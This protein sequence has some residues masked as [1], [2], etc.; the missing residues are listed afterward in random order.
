MAYAIAVGF[1]FVMVFCKSGSLIPCIITHSLV[2]I[3]ST[4][5]VENVAATSIVWKYAPALFIILVAGG[6]TL[7]LHKK[8]DNF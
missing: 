5:S 3:T 6:Y 2:N 4:F 1:A 7:Y 8:I